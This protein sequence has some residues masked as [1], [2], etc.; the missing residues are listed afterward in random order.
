M[1]CLIV[2]GIENDWPGYPFCS[3]LVS[4]NLIDQTWIALA[5]A[6]GFEIMSFLIDIMCETGVSLIRFK[7]RFSGL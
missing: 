5:I 7:N 1:N 2:A 3:I 6:T 4:C